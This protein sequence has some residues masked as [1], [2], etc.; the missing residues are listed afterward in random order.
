MSPAAFK[1]L[2]KDNKGM[3]VEV[4]TYKD[5]KLKKEGPVTDFGKLRASGFPFCC[6]DKTLQ[7]GKVYLPYTSRSQ[8]IN[9]GNQDKN[10]GSNCSRN[11]GAMLCDDLLAGSFI[12]RFLSQS[13][14][15]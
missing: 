13:R 6:Y 1:T 4:Q 10:L 8:S 15:N 2:L 7:G 12:A 11:S 3:H 5:K 14:D 9:E